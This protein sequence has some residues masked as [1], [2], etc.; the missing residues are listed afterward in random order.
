MSHWLDDDA[1]GLSDGRYNCRQVL[2]RGSLVAGGALLASVTTPIENVVRATSR[3]GVP[4]PDFNSPCLSPNTCCGGDKCCD[5]ATEFCCGGGCIKR[6]PWVA[7]CH[8]AG[9]YDPKIEKCCPNPS[10][11]FHACDKSEKCCG[12]RDCCNKSE[13]CCH[14]GKLAY[15]APK[16]HCCPKGQHRVACGTG[17]RLCCPDDENC[18]GGTCCKTGQCHNGK[19]NKSACSPSNPHGTCPSGQ[20]CCGGYCC[21]TANCSDGQCFEPCGP[22]CGRP[23]ALAPC[24]G[25]ANYDGCCGEGECCTANYAENGV[26]ISNICCPYTPSFASLACCGVC[27]PHGLTSTCFGWRCATT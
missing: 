4:C 21:L 22:S 13:Q 25:G 14:S 8:G 19:C 9:T 20:T 7:C 24:G 23:G 1:R 10:G 6:H 2:R 12:T 3:T 11:Q 17:K 26:P 16:G 27:C 5:N 18:C 15:C